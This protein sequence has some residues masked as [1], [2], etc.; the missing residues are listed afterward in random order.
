MGEWPR[1][2]RPFLLRRRAAASPKG[3]SDPAQSSR[4]PRSA[5]VIYAYFI[6]VFVTGGSSQLH[7]WTDVA[8]QLLAL[9]VLGIGLWRLADQPASRVRTLGLAAMAAVALL[10]WLQLLPLPQAWWA[11]APARA[12]LAGDLSAAGV[13]D[14][15][16]TWSLTPAATL[17]S[18]LFLL[19][20]LALFAWVLGSD[21]RTQRR[22]LVLCV[23]MP[24]ASLILGFL[25][26]GAPQDSLLFPYPQWRAPMAGTFANPN[27][28]GTAMLIGLGICLAFAAGAIGARDPASG[29]PRNPWPAIIAGATLLLALPLTNSRAAVVIGVL[30]LAA[31]PLGMAASALRRSGRGRVGALALV[32]AAILAA[33]GLSAAMGWMKVDEVDEIRWILRQA[34]FALGAAHLPWGSGIGS[35]VPVFQQAFPESLLMPAYMNAAHNDYAQVWLEGG[36][37]GLL[38]AVLCAVALGAAVASYLRR[39]GGDRRL[40]WAGMLG[41]FALLAHAGADYALRTPALMTV[42]AVLAAMLIAQGARDSRPVPGGR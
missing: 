37:A 11:W 6:L 32:G 23:A 35:F 27:H 36:V 13:G 25:Q 42:A 34:T 33:I 9:P 24:L 29:K 1:I 40:L 15:A 10:P 18:A 31:A 28:Q 16:T 3:N 17:R 20:G 39:H 38:V 2:A 41:V 7:G 5:A 19:P 4:E 8:A 22:L 12:S 30:M 26:L 21:T 14:Y